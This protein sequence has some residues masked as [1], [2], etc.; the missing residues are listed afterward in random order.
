MHRAALIGLLP[1]LFACTGTANPR[2]EARDASPG[3]DT[4]TAQPDASGEPPIVHTYA[5]TYTAIWDEIF[6]PTCALVFCHGGSDADY[7]VLVNEQRGYQSMFHD[8]VGPDCASLGIP[9]VTPGDPAKSLLYRKITDAPCG[10]RMPNFYGNPPLDPRE[11]DQIKRWIEL[12]APYDAS[13]A[14]T[15][16]SVAD[17]APS[18]RDGSNDAAPDGFGR[19]SAD[20]SLP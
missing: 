8:K 11:V 14:S 6:I 2:H 16:G 7:L 10:S 13:E 4:T 1:S 3:G 18:T 20:S 5:P 19:R 17:A 12:G 15:D 9:H